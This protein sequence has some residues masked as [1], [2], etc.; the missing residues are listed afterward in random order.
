VPKPQTQPQPQVR[1]PPR[2]QNDEN[3]L[4]TRVQ[5][6]N[7]DKK[8]K[9]AIALPAWVVALGLG[10]GIPA[11]LVVVPLLVVSAIRRRRA[12]RR[13]A[14]PRKRDSVAG[15]WDELLD[16]VGELG[17]ATPVATTRRRTAETL[18][19]H[20]PRRDDGFSVATLARRTDDAVFSGRELDDAEVDAVWAEVISTVDAARAAL[21]RWRRALARYR[22]AAATGWARRVAAVVAAQVPAQTRAARTRAVRTR[23]VRMRAVTGRD[24]T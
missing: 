8:S 6:D 18:D 3:D 22:L 15:A 2:T 1:Q 23:A 14:A 16:R 4:V 17:I 7:T 11:L 21:P 19:P 24:R 13:R 10:V 12:S 5:I 20:L 9:D